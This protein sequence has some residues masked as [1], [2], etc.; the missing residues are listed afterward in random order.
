MKYNR[1]CVVCKNKYETNYSQKLTCCDRCSI[2]HHKEKMCENHRTREKK[3]KIKGIKL[4]DTCIRCGMC[5]DVCPAECI[6]VVDYAVKDPEK[7]IECG[8]CM[9]VCPE[10]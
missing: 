1:E 9:K 3:P 4:I 8:Q 7:C 6:T 2:I 10:I 5:E